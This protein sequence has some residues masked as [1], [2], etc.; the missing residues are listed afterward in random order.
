MLKDAQ[1]AK[2]RKV[3]DH[4][5]DQ[6][7]DLFDALSDTSRYRIVL[8]LLENKDLCV[9]DV[10]RVLNISVPAASQQFRILENAGIVQRERMGQMTCYCVNPSNMIVKSVIRLIGEQ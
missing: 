6:L 5:P 10:A 3:L 2:L 8:L 7:P 9:T 4:T 1:I